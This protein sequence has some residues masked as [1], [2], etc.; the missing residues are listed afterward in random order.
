MIRQPGGAG[1]DGDFFNLDRHP[2][3]IKGK[4]CLPGILLSVYF[5]VK[6][7]SPVLILIPHR[8]LA[9]VRSAPAPPPCPPLP[10]SRGVDRRERGKEPAKERAE[11]AGA[12]SASGFPPS[13]SGSSWSAL[14][15]WTA[16][17]SPSSPPRGG[18]GAPCGRSPS[19]P[20]RR[21][22]TPGSSSRRPSRSARRS[23]CSS[24]IPR[25][26]TPRRTRCSRCSPR[27]RR[28]WSRPAA[29]GSS[30]AWTVSAGS[31]APPGT[32]CAACSPRS[33]ASSPRRS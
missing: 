6:V 13:S 29:V 1:S 11:G 14:P 23:P 19:A 24:P 4:P 20:P 30:W 3:E 10:W 21:G 27:S 8:A 25:T 16:L 31:T 33:S 22:C 12:P 17:R 15:P 18:R 5:R 2:G 28:W 32:R 26:T 7:G 9:C